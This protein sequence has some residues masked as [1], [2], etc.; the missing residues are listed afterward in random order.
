L[1]CDAA[2]NRLRC[3]AAVGR[4]RRDAVIGDGGVMPL[5][6]DDGGATPS[7]SWRVGGS[8]QKLQ[9]AAARRRRGRALRGHRPWQGEVAVHSMA[10]WS[11]VLRRHRSRK[12]MQ[13]ICFKNLV[14]P[15]KI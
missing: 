4:R 14:K 3:D 5:R 8:Q 15:W 1:Q 12:G 10:L 7:S 6:G 11:L 13:V 9:C 2:D